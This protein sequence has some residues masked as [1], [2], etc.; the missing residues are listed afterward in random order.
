MSLRGKTVACPN[1]YHAETCGAPGCRNERQIAH[2]DCEW[3][4]GS[5]HVRIVSGDD[6]HGYAVEAVAPASPEAAEGAPE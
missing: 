5:K 1:W 3:C 4:G 2:A 6:D